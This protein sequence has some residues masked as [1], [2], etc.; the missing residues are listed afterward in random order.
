MKIL[1]VKHLEDCFDGSFINEVLFDD[2]IDEHFILRMGILGQLKYY[3]DFPLPFFKINISSKF[4]IK[5]VEGKQ[6]IRVHL[7]KPKEF[8][9]HD[10]IDLIT[11]VE[12]DYP[13][14]QFEQKIT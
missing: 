14:M 11:R 4:E 1:S 12:C 6:S 13:K 3:K 10:V 5:G 2:K 9:L 8:N 7:K